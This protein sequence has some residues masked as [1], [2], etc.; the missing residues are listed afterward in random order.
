MEDFPYQ[1]ELQQIEINLLLEGMYQMYGFDFRHY[2]RSSLR[3]RILNRMRAEKLPT[4]SAVLEKVLHEPG[5]VELLLNDMSIRVTE[6]FRDPSFF[7]AFRDHVVPELRKLPEIRIWH[8]GCATGEEVYSMAILMQEEGLAEKTRIYAT[9]MNDRAIEAAQKGAFPLKQMQL[10]TKNYLDA[11]GEM[12]FSEYYTTDH[13]YAYFRPLMRENLIFA[14][15][16]LVTDGSF[17]EFHVILCRN[18]MIYFDSKL[19]QQ[20]HSLFHESL[21]SGGYLGLGKK[22]SILFTPEGVHYEE[23]VPQE[24]IYRKK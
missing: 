16:N 6:M 13:Q 18:V 11:G 7:R 21:S 20:V 15:H 3:R 22:E 24:R 5:F 14:Q 2:V 8:A 4:I 12:A 10:F 17:N 1:D 9:D 19:Q 23:F